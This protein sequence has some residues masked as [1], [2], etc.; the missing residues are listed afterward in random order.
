MGAI[1]SSIWPWWLERPVQQS[2]WSQE[3]GHRILGFRAAVQDADLIVGIVSIEVALK[4]E[5]LD[6]ATMKD[7]SLE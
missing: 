1:Q 7:E 6:K 5:T 3:A 2:G 4:A